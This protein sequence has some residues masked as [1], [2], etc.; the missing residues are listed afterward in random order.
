[1]P[2]AVLLCRLSVGDSSPPQAMV[3]SGQLS[4]ESGQL[5]VVSAGKVLLWE[6]EAP[7]E[8]K[9]IVGAQLSLFADNRRPGI[10]DVRNKLKPEHS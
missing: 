2:F 4:V 8:P 5:S 10:S 3:D 1:M 6:G 7:A 9:S